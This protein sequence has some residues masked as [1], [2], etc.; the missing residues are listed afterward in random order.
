MLDLD[1]ALIRSRDGVT[2]RLAA[3]HFVRPTSGRPWPTSG[4]STSMS[5]HSKS[6]SR[7]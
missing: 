1:A 4:R 5:W 3:G 7:P 6:V 2:V